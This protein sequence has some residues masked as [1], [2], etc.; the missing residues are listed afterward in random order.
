MLAGGTPKI[1]KCEEKDGFKLSAKKLEK[2]ISK[3]KMA[4]FKLSI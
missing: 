4:Y 1:I 2:A 3:N